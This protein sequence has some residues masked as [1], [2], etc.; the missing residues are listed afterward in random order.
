[1]K[2]YIHA[3]ESQLRIDFDP[4]KLLTEILLKEGF[5]LNYTVKPFEAVTTNEISHVSDTDKE[6]LIC[7]DNT[8]E[9]ETTDYFKTHKEL[10]FS[11]LERGLDTTKKWNLA[12]SLGE[13]FKA[14]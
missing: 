2:D 3:K 11:C 12:N 5:K 14:I 6:A 9:S 7:L 4:D 1:M 8:I 13:K 10:K